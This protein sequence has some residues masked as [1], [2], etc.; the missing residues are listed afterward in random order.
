MSKTIESKLREIKR[1]EQK[2]ENQRK[3]IRTTS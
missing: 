3:K 2:L 1:K